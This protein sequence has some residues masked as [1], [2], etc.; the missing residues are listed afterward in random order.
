M[1]SPNTNIDEILDSYAKYQYQLHVE[2]D[3][4]HQMNKREA[5]EA[6]EALITAAKIAELNEALAIVEQKNDVEILNW[7]DNRIKELETAIM[8]D[9]IEEILQNFRLSIYRGLDDEDTEELRIGHITAAQKEAAKQIREFILAEVI[10]PDETP[11]PFD[12]SVV[13]DGSTEARNNLRA[14]QRKKLK[15]D[16]KKTLL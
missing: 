4:S 16:E 11:P 8:P 5:K 2:N 1:P 9:G 10:G 13:S 7:F 12:H 15:S 6:L 14:Q 3:G